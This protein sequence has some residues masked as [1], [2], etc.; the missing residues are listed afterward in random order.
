LIEERYN[1]KPGDMILTDIGAGF[2][3]R[4]TRAYWFYLFKTR[5]NRIKKTHLWQMIDCGNINIKYAEGKK[6]RRIQKRFRTLD[7]RNTPLSDIESRF[8]EFINFVN[9]PCSVVFGRDSLSKV[10]LVVEK[11]DELSLEFYE[12]KSY[13]SNTA[14]VIR[15]IP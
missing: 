11:I 3:V 12:E 9:L 5:M 7:L 15:I 1:V 2:L 8:D 13:N 10:K 14:P 6:Y 4:E